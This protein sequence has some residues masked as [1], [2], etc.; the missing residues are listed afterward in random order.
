MDKK[1]LFR[2]EAIEPEDLPRLQEQTLYRPEQDFLYMRL[3]SLGI[4]ALLVLGGLIP[5]A[6]SQDWPWYLWIPAYILVL[7]IGGAWEWR[8]FQERAYLIRER[9]VSYREG[10]LF[11]SFTSIPFNRLQHCEYSQGPLGKLFDLASVKVFT[12]GGAASDI[13]IQGLAVERAQRLRDYL[14]QVSSEYE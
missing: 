2:N 9:D 3:S 7:L 6:L 4:G 5:M 11:T 10:W 13:T 14:T 1:D 8:S 12:A